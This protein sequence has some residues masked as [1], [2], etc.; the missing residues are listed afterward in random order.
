MYL[1]KKYGVVF[2]TVLVL[3]VLAFVFVILLYGHRGV[4]LP[5]FSFSGND[6]VTEA[7]PAETTAVSINEY[8]NILSIGGTLK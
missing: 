1:L 4:L 5:T 8:I 2:L 3:L 7:P 6:A